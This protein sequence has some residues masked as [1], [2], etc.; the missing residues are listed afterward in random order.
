MRDLVSNVLINGFK[1]ET[2]TEPT[3]ANC[4]EAVC[5]TAVDIFCVVP[6]M[7]PIVALNLTIYIISIYIYYYYHT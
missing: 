4:R 7:S 6:E 1:K 2:E 5:V 3:S